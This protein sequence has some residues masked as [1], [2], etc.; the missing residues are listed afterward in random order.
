MAISARRPILAAFLTLMLA[1]PGAALVAPP[2][3]EA[4]SCVRFSSGLFNAPGNDNLAANLNGEYVRIKNY[5]TTAKSI[6]GWKLH[7]YGRKNTYTFATGFSVKPGVVV[8]IFSGRGTN[9]STK[10]FWGRTS[11]EIWNN[12]ST[13]RAYLRNSAGTL[14]STWPPAATPTPTPK[15]P[16]AN[17]HPSYAGVC[18]TPGIGDY[19][20]AGGSGNGPN[21]V[22]GPVRVVG[23][24]EFDLDRD[25]DGIGCE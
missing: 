25:N 1:L 3:V 21:Y 20:C 4:A 12:T 13:E 6:S 24:D 15:P 9:S 11:G 2:N 5:C 17:C 8:T 22:A 19:D 10:R 7:D 23:W 14:M 16:A 18:L